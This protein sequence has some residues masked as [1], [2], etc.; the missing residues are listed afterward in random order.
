MKR[1]LILF[2]VCSSLLLTGCGKTEPVVEEKAIAVTV[3]MA[4]G[5]EIENT[6]TFTG[7]TKVSEET[8]VTAEMAGTIDK[9]NVKLGDHVSEGQV[10]LSINGKD[11]DNSIKTA[12]AALNLAEANYANTTGGSIE[13]QQNNLD[14]SIKLAQMS[15]DEAKRNYDIYKSLYDTGAI[16]QDQFKKIE[17]SLDQATQ[18]LEQSQKSYDTTTGQSI[19]QMKELAAKQLEQAKTAYQ[20]ATAS[21]DKLTVKSPV[22]GTITTKNFNEGEMISQ[23]QPAFIISSQN[24]L[25][26]DLKVTQADIEKF[27]Q[28]ESVDV[29]IDGKHTQGTVKYVPSVI[30]KNTSLYTVQITIDNSGN[31]FKEGLSAEVSISVEKESN[32]ITIPKKAVFED[33]DGQSYVYIV[34]PDNEAIKTEVETGII[35]D[36]TIEVKNGVGSSDTVVIGGLNNISDGTK[37]YPVE[38]ED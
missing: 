12:Q 28:G 10:L 1:C 22:S 7:T 20:V 35:T 17:L 5:G 33:E 25:Q 36:K 34:S 38:K 2:L 21:K 4:K 24:V 14:N 18:Q 13:N 16:S 11:V 3:Q 23:Q 9:I 15:Y 27:K 30:D 31:E 32:A 29:T 19:P 37:I 8:S 26:I 6:N